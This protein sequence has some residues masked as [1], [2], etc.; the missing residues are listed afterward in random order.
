MQGRAVGGVD[1]V[2]TRPSDRAGPTPRSVA[3]LSVHTSPLAQ[4]GTGDGGGMNV[5]VAALASRLRTHDIRVHVF[6]R[7]SGADLP[8][9]VVLDDGVRVHHVEAGPPTLRKDDLASHLCAFYLAVAAHPAIGDV[10]LLDGHYWMSGWVG[11]KLAQRRSVPLVQRFH[12]LAHAKDAGR[13]ADE[14]PEPMLRFAAERRVVRA[15]DAVLAAT[16][17]EAAILGRAYRAQATR[18]HIVPP[19]VNTMTFTPDGDR[20]AVRQELGGGRLL[21]FVGRLQP[22]KG[23]DTAVRALA[24]LDRHLPDDGIP[25]RLLIVGGASGNGH[26]TVD[27]P[28]LRRLAAELGVA[29]RVAVLAPRPH[30]ELAHLYRAADVVLMP[31]RSESFGLVALEAQA[32]GTPVVGTDVGGLPAILG[33]GGGTVVETHDPEAYA[34]AAVPYLLDAGLRDRAS[35]AAVRSARRYSWRRT[36]AQTLDVYRS[37][38]SE[39]VTPVRGR[40]GA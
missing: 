18:V 36:T 1:L 15:A 31:S 30:R 13:S 27:P 2:D 6:T 20:Q 23:P 9:T 17:H 40:R 35:Q 25:T 26:G 22:L 10:D 11:R 32:C 12:T 14:P 39:C 33:A 21:L 5:F 8:P 4:P 19:G 34:R 38:L 3:L 16:S 7:A 24:A 37:V 28:A 29:D